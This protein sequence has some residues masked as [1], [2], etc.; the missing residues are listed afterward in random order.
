[1]VLVLAFSPIVNCSVSMINNNIDSGSGD[2]EIDTCNAIRT[3]KYNLKPSKM[4]AAVKFS[5]KVMLRYPVNWEFSYYK[6]TS[7]SCYEFE[8]ET[9]Q[10]TVKKKTSNITERIWEVHKKEKGNCTPLH[11][12]FSHYGCVYS[13]F[14]S[15]VFCVIVLLTANL[16]ISFLYMKK[17]NGVFSVIT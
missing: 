4:S 10:Q 7:A 11:K 15:L 12:V 16:D 9:R 14:L 2:V 13:C 3:T 17:I 1:M 6:G 8:N 5:R